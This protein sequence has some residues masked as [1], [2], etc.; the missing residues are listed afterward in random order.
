LGLVRKKNLA[1]RHFKEPVT[2]AKV[3][4]RQEQQQLRG[5][6]KVEI[7]VEKQISTLRCS[8]KREQLRSK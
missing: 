4:Q 1:R 6:G 3:K 5:D 7:T 8:Q 2:T